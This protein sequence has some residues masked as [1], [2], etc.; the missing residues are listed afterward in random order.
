MSNAYGDAP[1]PK[2]DTGRKGYLE[3]HEPPDGS[4]RRIS[5]REFWR[6][7]SERLT[8]EH[9]VETQPFRRGVDKP[10]EYI[11][12]ITSLAQRRLSPK[13][14]AIRKLAQYKAMPEPE[15]RL[16]DAEWNERNN[17]LQA[18]REAVKHV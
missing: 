2:E 17:A 3:P 12:R 14:D 11:T 8:Y 15:R 4:R 16:T 10:S 9:A 1:D 18:Q 5:Y 7:E 6:D 13:A